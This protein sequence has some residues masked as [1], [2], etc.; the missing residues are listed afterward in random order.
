MESRSRAGVALA[1]DGGLRED[2][3]G[4]GAQRFPFP[5]FRFPGFGGLRSSSFS[6]RS[7]P[8]LPRGLSRRPDED[9]ADCSFE[10]FRIASANPFGA[11]DRSWLQRSFEFPPFETFFW[12]SASASSAF[13]D[14]YMYMYM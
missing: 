6:S 3:G 12:F 10:A 2:A 9:E 11:S 4:L 13:R 5:R 14:T 8:R 1:P 7:F